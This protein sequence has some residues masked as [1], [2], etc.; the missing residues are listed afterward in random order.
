[1]CEIQTTFEQVQH[2]DNQSVLLQFD[3]IELFIRHKTSP[4]LQSQP[5]QYFWR[6]FRCPRHWQLCRYNQNVLQSICIVHVSRCEECRLTFPPS[7]P[8]LF[9][10]LIGRV[11]SVT[12]IYIYYNI[13]YT[14]LTEAINVGRKIQCVKIELFGTSLDVGEGQTLMIPDQKNIR[15]KMFLKFSCPDNTSWHY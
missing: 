3:Q 2:E 14:Y 9:F 6:N 15:R 7:S 10:L 5:C 11:V 1:M 4:N 12:A 8:A 13:I